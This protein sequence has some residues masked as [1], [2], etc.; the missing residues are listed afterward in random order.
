MTTKNFT[1][2]IRT[3]II[4]QREEGIQI[5]IQREGLPD[6]VSFI[7]NQKNWTLIR[8]NGFPALVE[9]IIDEM[10]NR[11]SIWLFLGGQRAIWHLFS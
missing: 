10:R 8:G 2:N 5:S 7:G 4:Y 11:V 9:I 3:L 1:T 6:P